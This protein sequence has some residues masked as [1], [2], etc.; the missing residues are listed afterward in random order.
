MSNTFLWPVKLETG[1]WFLRQVQRAVSLMPW[2]F[3]TERLEQIDVSMFDR[4]HAALRDTLA[5]LT[6]ALRDAL[7]CKPALACTEA[8][9]YTYAL[10]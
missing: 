6:T 1:A 9:S 8:L 5:A 7:R 10:L 2:S 3:S 4:H